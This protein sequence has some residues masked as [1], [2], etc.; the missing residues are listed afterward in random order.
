MLNIIQRLMLLKFSYIR[1]NRMAFCVWQ[2]NEIV[3][4]LLPRTSLRKV[5]QGVLE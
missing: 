5:A 2:L 1:I 3:V 4:H